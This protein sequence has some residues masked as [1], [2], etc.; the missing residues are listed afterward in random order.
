VRA[1]IWEPN[2]IA[3]LTRSPVTAETG[4]QEDITEQSGQ[5]DFDFEMGTW[6]IHLSRLLHPP[7]SSP[8]WVEFDGTSVTRKV[9]NGRANVEEFETDGTMGRIEGLSYLDGLVRQLEAKKDSS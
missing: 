9:W 3:T 1:K 5:H 8:S 6:K 4:A 7:T 2:F